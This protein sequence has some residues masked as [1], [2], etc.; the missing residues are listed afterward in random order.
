[1]GKQ[2]AL[3]KTRNFLNSGSRARK[4]GLFRTDGCRYV[5]FDGKK[6][7]KRKKFGNYLTDDRKNEKKREKERNMNKIRRKETAI[8]QEQCS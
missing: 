5:E 3:D 8:K 7:L 4:T 1:M 6:Q 2:H